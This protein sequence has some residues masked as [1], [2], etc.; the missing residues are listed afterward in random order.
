[1]NEWRN[2]G[3]HYVCQDFVVGQV[4]DS[5]RWQIWKRGFPHTYVLYSTGVPM[6]FD[7]AEAAMAYV[8]LCLNNSTL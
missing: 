3:G 8:D 4:I 2:I 6:L 1:M 5:K 7:T